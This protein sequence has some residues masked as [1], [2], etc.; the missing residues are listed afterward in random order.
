MLE[1]LWL[2]RYQAAK[3]LLG[4]GSTC[5]TS[6][7]ILPARSLSSPPSL[8]RRFHHD[9]P[10]LY[11]ARRRHRRHRRRRHRRHHRH[12]YDAPAT[13]ATT[14]TDTRAASP[15]ALLRDRLALKRPPLARYAWWC[16]RAVNGG[17]WY[18]RA[19]GGAAARTR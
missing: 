14:T 5:C 15:A 7:R 13:A 9:H 2:S 17:L 10:R 18:A 19:S 16:C 8:C 6:T 12:V 3:L 4:S 1:Q 11:L